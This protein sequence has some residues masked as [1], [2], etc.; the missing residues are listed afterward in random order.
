M[1]YF[2]LITIFFKFSRWSI[3]FITAHSFIFFCFILFLFIFCKLLEEAKV[4]FS[5]TCTHW[6]FHHALGWK[7]KDVIMMLLILF[8]KEQVRAKHVSSQ[9]ILTVPGLLNH[10]KH[11]KYLIQAWKTAYYHSRLSAHAWPYVCRGEDV[12]MC[13]S[14]CVMCTIY[15]LNVSLEILILCSNNRLKTKSIQTISNTK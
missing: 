15:S 12:S 2:H 3:V 13:V 7:H 5:R 4:L 6:N 9:A 11:K 8:P 1:Y 10:L 14:L